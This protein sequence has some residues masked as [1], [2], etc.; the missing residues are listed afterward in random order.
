MRPSIAPADDS[1]GKRCRCAGQQRARVSSAPNR[2]ESC[3]SLT[4][5]TRDRLGTRP[6]VRYTLS[7]T[8]PIDWWG[9]RCS[10]SIML[11]NAR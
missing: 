1:V 3:Q 7:Y 6:S 11:T 4:H 5:Q 10:S 2:N 8:L 9:R